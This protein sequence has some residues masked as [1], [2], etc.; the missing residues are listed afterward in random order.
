MS[1]LQGGGFADATG[2]CIARILMDHYDRNA[3]II[4]LNDESK[5]SFL[6]KN[7][8]LKN[9]EC[10]N[11]FYPS[12]ASGTVH[13]SSMTTAI[14]ARIVYSPNWLRFFEDL[15]IPKKTVGRIVQNKTVHCLRITKESA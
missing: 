5:I 9:I 3:F 6:N 2:I 12:F 14:L 13:F 8:R 1:G 11:F 15:T 7:P 4:Q 10:P